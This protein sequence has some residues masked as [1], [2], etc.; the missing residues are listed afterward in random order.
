MISPICLFIFKTH[1]SLETP[2]GS[3][4]KA[5]PEYKEPP[6]LKLGEAASLNTKLHY[7]ASSKLYVPLDFKE[8]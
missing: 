5:T 1:A 4:N 6:C 8:R 2:R 3:C 7:K